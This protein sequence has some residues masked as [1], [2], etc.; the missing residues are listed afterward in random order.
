[1]DVRV[2]KNDSI[3]K[4]AKARKPE[5]VPIAEFVQQIIDL[6]NLEDPDKL[7]IGQIIKVP[8]EDVPSPTT[9][10]GAQAEIAAREAA[11]QAAFDDPSRGLDTTAERRAIDSAYADPSRKSDFDSVRTAT[12]DEVVALVQNGEARRQKAQLENLSRDLGIQFNKGVKTQRPIPPEGERYNPVP[13]QKRKLGLVDEVLDAAGIPA[14]KDQ[15]RLPQEDVLDLDV[16]GLTPFRPPPP[17]RNLLREYAR[18]LPQPRPQ[19]VSQAAKLPSAPDRGAFTVGDPGGLVEEGNIDLGGVRVTNA[20]GT[21]SDAKA[22]SFTDD[23]GSEVLLPLADASGAEISG[24]DAIGVYRETG[25][26]LGK[27]E[28]PDAATA[29]AKRLGEAQNPNIPRDPDHFIDLGSERW[30]DVFIRAPAEAA[31]ANRQRSRDQERA[32]E[33]A[34]ATRKAATAIKPVPKVRDTPQL[35]WLS[36]M[37]TGTQGPSFQPTKVPNAAK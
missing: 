32:A 2:S 19:Y 31:A 26:H 6:N 27:F 7:Q 25:R 28:T 13:P 22:A 34:A 11:R 12:P 33:D 30:R 23:D 8:G 17:H 36:N 35:D 1:M 16:L 15:A 21:I 18:S 5:G 3:W 37:I 24:A 4:I 20:D 9:R 29:Y 14:G 10:A